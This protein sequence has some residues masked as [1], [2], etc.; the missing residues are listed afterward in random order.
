[1]MDIHVLVLVCCP[2]SCR[3]LAL[4]LRIK[5]GDWFRVMHIIKSGGAGKACMEV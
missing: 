5:I 3:D 4:D 2:L 1:M